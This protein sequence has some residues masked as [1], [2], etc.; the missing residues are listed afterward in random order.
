M[1]CEEDLQMAREGGKNR[2]RWR[3]KV[4]PHCSRH[5]VGGNQEVYFFILF[6]SFFMLMSRSTWV[7]PKLTLYK[8]TT[9]TKTHNLSSQQ[10]SHPKNFNTS[11][12]SPVTYQ[13]KGYSFISL[14]LSLS[15]S[16]YIPK[17]GLWFHEK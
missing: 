11:L 8:A 3:V 10:N 6:T 5:A 1:A 14:S 2:Q 13:Q 17:R 7:L 12:L 4:F 16:R 9:M 15:L